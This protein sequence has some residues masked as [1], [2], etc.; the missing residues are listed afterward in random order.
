MIIYF[1]DFFSPTHTLTHTMLIDCLHLK[2]HAN[3]IEFHSE[4][5]NEHHANEPNHAPYGIEVVGVFAESYKRIEVLA[6]WVSHWITSFE[7]QQYNQHSQNQDY[8]VTL[9]TSNFLDSNTPW[10][11]LIALISIWCAKHGFVVPNNEAWIRCKEFSSVCCWK[12]L[13]L[14]QV[15]S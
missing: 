1:N 8:W 10:Q 2:N 7:T 13:L 5:W 14:S 3:F 4:R 11:S 12:E 6:Y 15:S 9:V